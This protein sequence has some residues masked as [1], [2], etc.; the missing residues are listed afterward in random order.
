[1]QAAKK[2]EF[3]VYI[4]RNKIHEGKEL[5]P[6]NHYLESNPDPADQNALGNENC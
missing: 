1:M 5:Q 6:T 3:H 2:G 4:R